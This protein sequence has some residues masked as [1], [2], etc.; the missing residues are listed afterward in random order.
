MCEHLREKARATQ[1][2]TRLDTLWLDPVIGTAS[3]ITGSCIPRLVA[4]LLDF[5]MV[6]EAKHS[7]GYHLPET[8]LL[9]SWLTLAAE[10]HT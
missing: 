8:I 3:R 4:R 10:G 1:E 5:E 6:L 2:L 7:T 9:L